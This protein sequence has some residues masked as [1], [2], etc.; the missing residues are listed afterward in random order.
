MKL[1]P[2]NCGTMKFPRSAIIQDKTSQNSPDSLLSVPIEAFLIEHPEGFILFD[3]GCDP[4]GMKGTWP[5]EY[6]QIPFE[7]RYLPEQLGALGIAP[8]DIRHVIASHLHFDHS[9]CLHPFGKAKIY[10][11]STEYEQTIY[12]WE[13]GLDMNAHLKS[14]VQ[15]WFQAGLT[16][17]KIAPGVREYPLADGVT[18]LNLGPGHSWGMLGLM[19]ELDSGNYLLVSDAIYTK[20]Y[21]GPPEKLPGLLSDQE[22]YRSTV[23]FIQSYASKHNAAIIF[24]HDMEQFG[25]LCAKGCL[26]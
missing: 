9:G 17:Q 23:G 20:E 24:G 21:Q 14:D 5:A 22:G 10:V 13:N 15:N 16:W 25:D 6:R 8:D 26:E 18:L 19:V 3:T 2:L 11:S 1:F 4:E 7:G 12:L